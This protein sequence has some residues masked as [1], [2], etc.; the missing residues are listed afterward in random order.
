MPNPCDQPPASASWAWNL[1]LI[2]ALLLLWVAVT[3]LVP[4][5]ALDLRLNI[6]GWPFSFWMSAQGTLLVYWVIVALYG[7]LLNR[8][9]ARQAEAPRD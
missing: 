8:R 5:F 3:F 1:R 9:D 2:A 7:W 6:G 4:Y